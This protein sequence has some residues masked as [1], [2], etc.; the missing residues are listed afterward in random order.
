MDVT[1]QAASAGLSDEELRGKLRAL[2]TWTLIRNMIVPACGIGGFA[3][4]AIF[5]INEIWGGVIASVAVA[6]ALMVS[7][8]FTAHG[9]ASTLK[10]LMGGALTLP[11]L[12]EAFEVNNY[13]P[14]GHISA[15]LVRS[16][17]LIDDWN[18]IEGS[19]L[20]EGAYKGTNILYSDLHLEREE[21]ERD[22]DGKV[23][24][25]YVTVF[26]GQWL[27]CDFG[28]ELAASLRLIERRGGTK[29]N[30]VH[31]VSKSSVETE[32]AAF[33]KKFRIITGDGHTAFYLLTPH[34][35]E[36]LVAA[37]EA[38]DSSTLFC[39]KGGKAHIALYSGRD[40]FELK[41]VKL[42]S[43]DNA[44]QKFRSDLKYMTGVMDILLAHD[45]LF[46]ER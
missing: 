7:L 13:T 8:F 2:K 39:F 22:E 23:K 16:A 4:V 26:K 14:G 15:E 42:D 36:R 46:K 21:T 34:F 40:S 35:M 11:V 1:K 17:G 37:D 3:G 41:G 43:V 31:D 38:A 32:N 28:K 12:R 24:K 9:K 30:R 33:N 29:W 44:R 19:D 6:F 25:R 5:G 45:K 20:I 18:K 10:D 27:V